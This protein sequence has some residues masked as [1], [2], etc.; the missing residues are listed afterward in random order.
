MLRAF[1][2]LH[3]WLCE[4]NFAPEKIT[5]RIQADDMTAAR[6]ANTL[7]DEHSRWSFKAENQFGIWAGT[8]NG[9]R[10]EIEGHEP[11]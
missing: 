7:G 2:A 1:A 3:H 4:H 6:L 11:K 10:F 5:V 9:I 8:I